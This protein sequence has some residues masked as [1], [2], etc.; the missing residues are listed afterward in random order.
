[1]L[2]FFFIEHIT[3]PQNHISLGEETERAEAPT[4]NHLRS[5]K[6]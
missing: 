4:N 5:K 6:R 3:V 2:F 1:M